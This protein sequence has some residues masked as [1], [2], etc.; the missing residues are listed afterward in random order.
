MK[1]FPFLMLL[2]VVFV[3]LCPIFGQ[4]VYQRLNVNTSVATSIDTS[5][6]ARLQN[7]ETVEDLIKAQLT[8]GP[9]EQD[10]LKL[11]SVQTS[12]DKKYQFITWYTFD[13]NAVFL[14]KGLIYDVK[15]KFITPL[16]DD[17]KAI[18]QK[19]FP[20]ESQKLAPEQWLG[21]FYYD[22][23]TKKVQGTTYYFLFG[24]RW[25]DKM[26]CQK[27]IEVF[28]FDANGAVK[29]GAPFF[30]RMPNPIPAERFL[31]RYARSANVSLRYNKKL[32][33]IVFDRIAPL[34]PGYSQMYA[35]YVPTFIYDALEWKKN[36]W[37]W[38]ENLEVQNEKNPLD[39][40]GPP[41]KKNSKLN[42]E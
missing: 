36:Q 40:I 7:F 13:S 12:K 39:L 38:V 22:I 30:D 25:V 29:L 1:R 19:K 32:G 20:V 2:S 17:F 8:Q 26:E 35:Y 24:V 42:F 27:T 34:N 9:L 28:S 33:K 21:A 14:Y 16:K 37:R 23:L 31:M 5:S 41:L 3:G 18:F 15:S 11:M 10:S 6:L 4:T